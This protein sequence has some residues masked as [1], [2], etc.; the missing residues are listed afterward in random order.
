VF[1]PI[2]LLTMPGA[3]GDKDFL[4]CVL[5]DEMKEYMKEA[6]EAIAKGISDALGNLH[7]T[8]TLDRF[9]RRISTL[10]L[11]TAVC[12]SLFSATL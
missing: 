2:F 8:D 1:S 10:R 6:H 7:I 5:H 11:F 12:A 4:D 3:E 9:D